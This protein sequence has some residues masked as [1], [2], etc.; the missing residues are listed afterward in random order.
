MAAERPNRPWYENTRSLV[1]FDFPSGGET[2]V[3][4]MFLSLVI[5]FTIR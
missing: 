4:R 2:L 3:F 5:Q 1:T